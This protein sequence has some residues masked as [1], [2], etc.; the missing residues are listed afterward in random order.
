MNAKIVKNTIEEYHKSD[1]YISKSM[2]AQILDCPFKY[3][4]Y[5]ILGNKQ[6]EK[7]HLNVGNAVH[8]LALEP[9]L[10]EKEYYILTEGITRN[11]KFAKYQEQLEIAK[12][13]IIITSKDFEEIER[14]ANALTS[15]STSKL[16]LSGNG[17]IETSIYWEEEFENSRG[18][19]VVLKFKCRPDW[20]RDDDIIVDLKT[21]HD[22]RPFKF[23]YHARDF[24][25]DMSV[26]LTCRGFKAL[27]GKKPENNLFLLDQNKEPK[28]VQWYET[29]RKGEDSFE[30]VLERG[31]YRL[32]MAIEKLIECQTTNKWEKYA[33]G[34]T[35]LDV[36]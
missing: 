19:K 12:N 11:P 27:H 25:Y 35:P 20:W 7:D 34:I 4:Y 22:V 23:K 31:N 30:S 29:F 21:A 1:G 6:E 18:E 9:R 26:A 32:D 33:E 28:I 3:H 36:V 8:T 16:L 17:K 13:R 5:H 14:M 10:F 15:D 2:L 24:A